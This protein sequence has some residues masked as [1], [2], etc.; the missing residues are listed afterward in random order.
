[1]LGLLK[2]APPGRNVTLHNPKTRYPVYRGYRGGK[3]LIHQTLM[4]GE[5]QVRH[6]KIRFAN[7]SL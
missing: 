5:N 3:N 6:S 7:Q 2:L 4:F 1:M